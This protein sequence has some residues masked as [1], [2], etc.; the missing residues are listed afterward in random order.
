MFSALS[1]TYTP[2][3]TRH[4]KW[5]NDY[6]YQPL[7]FLYYPR[8]PC[9]KYWQFLGFKNYLS[10]LILLIP[11]LTCYYST[12]PLSSSFFCGVLE[13]SQLQSNL[14]EKRTTTD[15]TEQSEIKQYP[16]TSDL[17]E[18]GYFLFLSLK[19]ILIM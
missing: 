16:I 18:V 2:F 10:S 15:G 6:I 11:L 7:Y 9:Q 19:D 13:E 12:R 17:W 4:C 1:Y 14:I 5:F 3:L 8:E